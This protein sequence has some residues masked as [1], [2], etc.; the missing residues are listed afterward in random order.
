MEKQ[1]DLTCSIVV[2]AGCQT[3]RLPLP[4]PHHRDL[5]EIDGEDSSKLDSCLS[6]TSSTDEKEREGLKASPSDTLCWFNI[7][8][9]T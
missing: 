3:P 8:G 7:S 4:V 5:L 6:D 9:M 1:A 2:S